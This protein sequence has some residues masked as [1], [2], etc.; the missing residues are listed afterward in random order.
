[1][2]R[3]PRNRVSQVVFVEDYVQLVFHEERFSF[4]EAL[5]LESSQR[6]LT[7]GTAGFCD[8][9][10]SLIGKRAASVDVDDDNQ[11]TIVFDDGVTVRAG[12][13]SL[14]SGPEAWT[15]H[16]ADGHDVVGRD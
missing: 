15:F 3:V 11:L 13:D 10:V 9:L 8:S 4:L 7:S 12:F 2:V 16:G 6:V 14:G 5:A 1:M